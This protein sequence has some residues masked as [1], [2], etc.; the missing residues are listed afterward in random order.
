[1]VLEA[2]DVGDLVTEGQDLGFEFGSSSEAGLN[3]CKEGRD[4]R[5]RDDANVI[6]RDR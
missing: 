6:S 5:A 2:A 3:H 4:A 1:V